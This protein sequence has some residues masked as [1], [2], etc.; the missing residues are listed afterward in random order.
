MAVTYQQVIDLARLPLNDSD[1]VR[2]TDAQALL[3]AQTGIALLLNK[4]PDLFLGQF[5]ALPDPFDDVVGDNIPIDTRYKQA[6]ADYVTARCE[7]HDDENVVQQRAQL[8]F[9]LAGG[10]A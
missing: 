9:Q 3:Y 2:Y 10:Q 6:L 5:T 8:F 4:R 7:T 1:K